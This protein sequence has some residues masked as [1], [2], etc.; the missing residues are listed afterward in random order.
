MRQ[1]GNRVGVSGAVAL[2]GAL[3]AA[4]A[5]AAVITIGSTTGA[6]GG[7][8]TVAVS[9][10]TE[11]Q[12]VLAVQNRIGFER[13]AAIAAR[14]D[15]EPDCAVN[16]AI[17]KQATG[18][19]FLPLGCDPALDCDSLRVFVIAFDNLLP[20]PD[21]AQLYGCHVAIAANAALGDYPLR[22]S[23]ENA[24]APGGVLLATT[25]VDGNV[26]VIASSPTP[27]LTPTVTPTA[28][29]IPTATRSATPTGGLTA[30][31]TAMAITWSASMSC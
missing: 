1:L 29:P 22:S 2:V 27:T 16:P 3:W 6:P 31:A 19:R 5:P 24:S 23:E 7:D 17:D 9:L 11:G 13:S 10:Q 26:E 30:S 28:T 8:V 18:F 21:G 14:A 15:G 20:I 12:T 25:G 4:V